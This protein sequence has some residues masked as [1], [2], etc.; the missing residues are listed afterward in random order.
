MPLCVHSLLYL[1]TILSKLLADALALLL[2]VLVLGEQI[3]IELCFGIL[4]VCV[5]G[6]S[7]L[8]QIVFLVSTQIIHS[9]SWT[10]QPLLLPVRMSLFK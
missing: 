2:V 10:L 8:F 9:N 5:C 3:L 6:F 7:I 4:L 1:S